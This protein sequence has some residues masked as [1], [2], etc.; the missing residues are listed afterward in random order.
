MLAPCLLAICPPHFCSLLTLPSV[1]GWVHLCPSFG[2]CCLH[3][4][5][6]QPPGVSEA[7]DQEVGQPASDGEAEEASTSDDV[8]DTASPRRA[9]PRLVLR[10]STPLTVT[11]GSSFIQFVPED[12][13]RLTVGV[14]A[15]QQAPVIGKQW[16]S[17]CM[18]EDMHYKWVLTARSTP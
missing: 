12:T 17:W 4:R 1:S 5:T 3:I 13:F 15:H 6:F 8:K 14:D 16:F 2:V 9:V 7:D 11:R 18:F 10:R